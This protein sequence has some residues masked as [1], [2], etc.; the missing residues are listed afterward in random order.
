[1]FCAE[2][3]AN[4][5]R[6]KGKNEMLRCQQLGEEAQKDKRLGAGSGVYLRCKKSA[7]E[8]TWRTKKAALGAAE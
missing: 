5:F 3:T 8:K 6:Q 2:K 1:M 4:F 7:I